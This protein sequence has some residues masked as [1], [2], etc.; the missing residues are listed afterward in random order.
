MILILLNISNEVIVKTILCIFLNFFFRAQFPPNYKS[1][2]T[3]DKEIQQG[4]FLHEIVLSYID[5]EN[6]YVRNS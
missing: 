1:R 2:K 3:Q 4:M 6:W 5:V